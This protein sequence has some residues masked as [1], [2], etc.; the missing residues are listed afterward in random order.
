MKKKFNADEWINLLL[1]GN[2]SDE[3]RKQIEAWLVTDPAA[4]TQMSLRHTKVIN[5]L[6][7]QIAAETPDLKD[8]QQ[9][10]ARIR[11]RIQEEAPV[12]KTW[13]DRLD[14]WFSFNRWAMPTATFATASLV[15]GLGIFW[16]VHAKPAPSQFTQIAQVQSQPNISATA[17]QSKSGNATVVWVSGFDKS[18]SEFGQIW[19]VYSFRPDVT[20]TAYDSEQGN[21]TVIWVSGLDEPADTSDRTSS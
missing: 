16:F 11:E 17:Y 1:D 21:A 18:A 9:L 5:K 15:L 20:A 10:W 7:Q 13:R 8:S 3:Q 19:Q 12:Q 2:L 14:W 4:H 6:I